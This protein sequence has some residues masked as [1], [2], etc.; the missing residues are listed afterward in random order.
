MQ[1]LPEGSPEQQR[2]FNDFQRLSS[3]PANA[4]RLMHVLWNIDIRDLLPRVSCPALVLHARGD[5]RVPLEEGRQVAALIPGARF[6]PLE[7]R[8]HILVENEPAWGRLVEEV[9]AF[10]REAAFAPRRAPMSGQLASLS[11]RE[12]Q[13]LDLIAKGL[14]NHQIADCLFLSEKTVRNHINS[15][16][17]K[18]GV[19]NRAKAIVLAREAGL[20][21]VGSGSGPT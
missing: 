13:V 9:R 8:N 11:G 14:D 2:A 6:V 3:S 4:A 19:E 12:R 21:G 15:I 10:L 18:L 17:G 20:G 16:F 7:S 1:F 5:M